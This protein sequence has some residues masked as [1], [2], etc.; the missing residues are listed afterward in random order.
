MTATGMEQVSWFG[1]LPS[2]WATGRVKSVSR[3]VTDGAHISPDTNNGA[4]D[5]VSTKDLRDGTIDFAGSLKTSAATYE[6][7]ARTGCK[8]SSGD[9]LF[10]KD[11][12]VGTTALVD[13]DHDFVVASSLI[14]V[15]PNRRK[16]R[17]RFLL[18]AF[19]AR[20]VIEQ[21][22]T[23]T[24]GAGLP[25]LSVGNLARIE[26]PLP[27]L[28]EQQVIIDF[29][30]QETAEIDALVAK[31]KE[32]VELLRERRASRTAD[33]L[34]K[35]GKPDTQLRRVARIHTGITL[36][37]DMDP[38][39]P[40]WPYLRVANVQMGHVDL[41]E[42]KTINLSEHDASTATLRAGDVLMTEGGD[43]D[44]LGRGTVWGYYTGTMLH[45][46]HVFAVRPNRMKLLP[47]YLALWLD[48]PTAREY[49]YLTAK[50]TTNLASTNKSIVGRLP[51][52][53]P[54][55]ERQESV[56]RL[57][58][59]EMASI[60]AL[61]AKAQEHVALAKERRA[62]LVTAAV[63]GQLNVGAIRKAD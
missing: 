51:M 50:K 45:Q 27:P 43:I 47:E 63:T 36:S 49:F 8:P 37:G 55:P 24:R 25:R 59:D 26:I 1:D 16:I 23:M 22:R 15:S 14:I 13:G 18:Y 52:R 29:L 48:S 46:N 30:D 57:H 34:A 60:D 58:S 10:S 9:L 53:V 11:G 12:T 42:I 28:D 3:K 6:Y 38:S 40:S 31:Q 62:A 21:A 32:F 4:F 17:P 2:S 56:V 5:F 41:S 39:L 44:K 20:P 19:S 33:V 54:S 35:L 7:M 61:I